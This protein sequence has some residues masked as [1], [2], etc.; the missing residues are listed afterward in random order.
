MGVPANI[1][2]DIPAD[3]STD[4]PMHVP[5]DI[6][7]QEPADVPMHAPTNS[8]MHVPAD[9]PI[10]VPPANVPTAVRTNGVGDLSATV[11]VDSRVNS[12]PN[13]SA[14]APL[15]MRMDVSPDF[16]QA[17]QQMPQTRAEATMN[18]SSEP[19]A[20]NG[21]AAQSRAGMCITFPFAARTQ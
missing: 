4:V 6:P 10:R 15:G 20:Y 18:V 17:R 5:A 8:S 11:S 13:P 19:A 7:M 2:T 3:I 21:P 14:D 9:I 16:H 12:G 1:P